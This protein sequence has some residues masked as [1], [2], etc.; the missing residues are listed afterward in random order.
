MR[1]RS[2]PP[3]YD[4]RSRLLIL[5]T[6]PS[7]ASLE[8]GFYY[9]HPRNCFWLMLAELLDEPPPQDNAHKR[10]LLLANGIALWDV[11]ESCERQGSLDSAI[12]LPE[13]N[14]IPSL[15]Q[16]CP[17]IRTILFNG[18]TAMRLYKRLLPDA[19]GLLRQ[20]RMPSTSPAYT[21]PYAQKCAAWAREIYKTQE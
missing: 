1:I 19:W 7:E 4:G 3:V 10:A 8:Q 5:G 16:A 14:D 17:G 6:M 9:A 18:G 20:V 21:L 2:F 15:I 12:R 11:A 13:P